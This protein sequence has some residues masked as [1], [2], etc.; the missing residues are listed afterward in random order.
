[1]CKKRHLCGEHHTDGFFVVC[2]FYG[3][4]KKHVGNHADRYVGHHVHLHIHD[5]V[6]HLHGQLVDPRGHHNVILTLCEGSETLTE[7]KSEG[8]TDRLTDGGRC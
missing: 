5:H 4:G 3:V 2:G 8:I 1:M 6:S 7:W